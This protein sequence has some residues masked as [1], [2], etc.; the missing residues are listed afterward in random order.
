[1]STVSE[2]KT[3]TNQ[4]GVIGADKVEDL[5][6][7]KMTKKAKSYNNCD[8]SDNF[9]DN[10]LK[11]KRFGQKSM[12]SGPNR[13]TNALI[14]RNNLSPRLSVD[15]QS[16]YNAW[17]R[18][19]SSGSL[20]SYGFSKKDKDERMHLKD[21][22]EDIENINT[23]IESS[24]VCDSDGSQEKT[25]MQQ[26][27]MCDVNE[28]NKVNHNI[29]LYGIKDG[30]GS[31][32]GCMSDAWDKPL[33]T[34]LRTEQE[35]I[36]SVCVDSSKTLERPQQPASQSTEQ[37]GILSVGVDS[38]KT[39]EQP[40][41][42][43]NQSN[44]PNID[45]VMKATHV[46]EKTVLDGATPPVNTIIFENTNFK[47]APSTRVRSEKS[48]KLDETGIEQAVIS[49]FN[50]PMRN[51]L[52]KTKK[53]AD[54]M[55]MQ[56]S[57]TKEDNSD[58]KLDFFESELSHLTDDKVIK[59]SVGQDDTN[60]SFC[61]SFCPDPNSLDPN[62]FGKGDGQDDVHEAYSTSPNQPTT[63]NT[64]NVCKVKPTQQVTGTSGQPVH[65][66]ST[67]QQHSGISPSIVGHPLSPPPM[68]PVLGAE[69][70]LGQS[71]QPYTSNQHLGYQLNLGE[72]TQYSMSAITLPPTVL[73]N[74]TQQIQA[75]TGLYG[76][77][78]IDQSQVLAVHNIR[79][80][81]IST[82]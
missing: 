4:V 29:N 66:A 5:N 30:Q 34:H 43:A 59:H 7:M 55:Q 3:E 65:F 62:A 1:M 16:N 82:V 2:D 48:T 54:S 49:S 68:Q 13:C 40:Q 52:N 69:V 78:Q 26:Q 81:Q 58:M 57:F 73:F 41:Q 37:E 61:A 11:S 12:N 23:E 51:L 15:R 17:G 75:Q 8:T 36:L 47:S 71:P 14:R 77:F 19:N 46:S 20:K 45:K 64:T 18:Q 31:A 6:K 38:S 60:S 56:L 33:S 80:I 72:S 22:V 24:I 63:N 35:G 10:G 44:S 50:K 79:L 67:H 53:F 21:G 76:F 70:G 32:A 39:L 9:K 25:H 28:M 42:P 27:G 74:L